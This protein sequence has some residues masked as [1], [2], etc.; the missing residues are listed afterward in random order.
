MGVEV[1]RVTLPKNKLIQHSH[2]PCLTPNYLVSK[3]DAFTARNPFN[4]NDGLLRFVHQGEDNLWMVTDRRTNASRVMTSNFSFVNNHFWNCFEGK[5]GIIVD[6]V[7]ATENY[8]DTYFLRNLEQAH[9]DWDN[10]FHPPM[11]CTIPQTGDSIACEPLFDSQDHGPLFDYPTFSPLYKMDPSYR[12]FYA[13]AASSSKSRWFDQVIKVD[14]QARSVVATWSAPGI[15]MTEFDF[16]PSSAGTG[17]KLPHEDDGVLIGVI[18]NAT[19][20]SSSV[21]LLDAGTL[22]LQSLYD[23][24]FAVPFHAH[25]IVC[26]HGKP[27]YTNP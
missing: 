1:S 17:G 12:F 21:A 23:L 24:P 4:A 7:A 22:K 25:G 8:L 13:I 14:S 6:T 2:S 9:A 18:Y 27:C 15:F 19:Q 10:I 20:D 5:D 26:E 3:L 11:R 16:V